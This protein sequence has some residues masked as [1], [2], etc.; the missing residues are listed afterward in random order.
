MK[1]VILIP[2]YNERERL[3]GMLSSIPKGCFCS[4]LFVDDGSDD[5]S[6]KIIEAWIAGR[7]DSS[8]LKSVLNMG[9]SAALQKG[10][11]CL[12]D[13]KFNGIIVLADGDGQHDINDAIKLAEFLEKRGTDMEVACRDFSSYSFL[14]T[15]GNR[16]LTWQASLLTL[17]PWRDTQ[18]GLRAFRSECA[19]LAAESMRHGRYCCEQ[20][21]CLSFALQG[22]KC[23]N[24]FEI[25]VKHSRSNSTWRDAWEIFAAGIAAWITYGPLKNIFKRRESLF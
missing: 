18:C 10:L 3:P 20:E 19:H 15:I 1:T 11:H 17:F 14:K 5:G 23:G 24:S 25:G 21:M 13:E 12:I 8:L 16:F 9:K 4:F 2:I 6:D 7:S 22:K